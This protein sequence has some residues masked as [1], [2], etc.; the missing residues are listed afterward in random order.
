MLKVIILFHDVRSKGEYRS[1]IGITNH[2]KKPQLS[3]QARTISM[4]L[5]IGCPMKFI[6]FGLCLR[7]KSFVLSN[8]T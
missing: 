2:S 4:S 1:V 8:E 7:K 5:V 3:V 6:V